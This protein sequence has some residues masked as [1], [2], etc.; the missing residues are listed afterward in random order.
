MQYF[1]V[2][3]RR[4]EAKHQRQER[5]NIRGK[6]TKN[7]TLVCYVMIAEVIN[8]RGD[9]KVDEEIRVTYDCI[10]KIT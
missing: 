8:S 9:I 4:K 3:R 10:L 1:W 5:H 6:I 2:K 7:K